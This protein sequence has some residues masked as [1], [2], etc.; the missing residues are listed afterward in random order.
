[1]PI[2]QKT[3]I[4][5][6]VYDKIKSTRMA[7]Y[8]DNVEFHDLFTLIERLCDKSIK[9]TPEDID[10]LKLTGSPSYSAGVSVTD[11]AAR[12]GKAS[13]LSQSCIVL[14]YDGDD[15]VDVQAIIDE[16]TQLNIASIIYESWSS[17]E[18]NRFRIIIPFGFEVINHAFK[19]QATNYI[20]NQLS[21]GDYVDDCSFKWYQLMLPPMY[22]LHTKPRAWFVRG[23]PL[24][25]CMDE[26][27][28]V[29]FETQH[30]QDAVIASTQGMMVYELPQ[31]VL[32]KSDELFNLQV[33]NL[34]K[35]L[36]FNSRVNESL[37][38]RRNSKDNGAGCY[39]MNE[40]RA[41]KDNKLNKQGQRDYKRLLFSPKEYQQALAHQPIAWKDWAKSIEDKLRNLIRNGFDFK[42]IMHTNAGRGKSRLL[43]RFAQGDP[44][45]QR[46]V[47][48]FHTN[49]NMQSFIKNCTKLGVELQVIYGNAELVKK[50][51]DFSDDELIAITRT[52][53]KAYDKQSSPKIRKQSFKTIITSL[54]FLKDDTDNLMEKFQ[55]NRDAIN[56]TSKHLVMSTAK[57]KALVEYG[58][59]S[60]LFVKDVI[61]Q[62]EMT[63]GEFTLTKDAAVNVWGK[64]R[65]IPDNETPHYVQY[66]KR[67]RMCFLTAEL[68]PVLEMKHQ[69]Y[70]PTIICEPHHEYEPNLEVLMVQKTNNDKTHGKSA[71]ERLTEQ[72]SDYFDAVIVDGVGHDDN[73]VSSKGRNNLNVDKLC[74]IIS[75]PHP[76]R[77]ALA[78][79][80]T[81]LDEDEAHVLLMSDTANQ[82]VGRN[83]GYRHSGN[84]QC[85]LIMQHNRWLAMHNITSNVYRYSSW[86]AASRGAKLSDKAKQRALFGDFFDTLAA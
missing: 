32:T 69:D 17:K 30:S 13:T 2:F 79:A 8:V 14:D 71:R 47:F 74:V 44:N 46:Y 56:D 67:L 36:I 3:F 38:Y 9:T 57:F 76:K 26:I 70:Q 29:K 64:P 82:S 31:A 10:E 45:T 55:Q 80:S 68:A 15:T 40:G 25:S 43:Q 39:I 21:F 34:H 54:P 66:I 78:M 83:T 52:F 35:P 4:T 65:H 81:G 50:H 23:E 11:T 24:S 62:D 27:D 5:L 41:I 22:H 16:L 7:H 1:M 59:D 18:G 60:R 19:V 20:I 53:S 73:H 37:R 12:R 49:K 72:A 48:N 51:R 85:L 84:Q 58:F 28:K 77:I 6:S 61:F 33:N 42:A 63:L 75:D 86:I